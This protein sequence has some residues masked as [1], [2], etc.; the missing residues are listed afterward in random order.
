[1]PEFLKLLPAD[2]ARRILTDTRPVGTERVPLPSAAG[3]VLAEALA[4]PEDLPAWPRATMD[5][6]AVRAR[7]IG[8]ASDGTP[9]Y[10]SVVGTVP[11][12]GALAGR[13]GAAQAA[14]IS[15]GGM[16]PEGADAVVMIEYATAVRQGEIEV[17]KG[18]AAGDNVIRPGDDFR[19]GETVLPAGRRLRPQDLGGLAAFG[20]AEVAVHRRPRVAILSTGNEICEPTATPAPGQVRDINQYVLGAM[21]AA[22]GC[23][24]TYGGIVKDDAAALRE[25]IGRL[26][27]DHDGLVLSG[28]SSVGVRDVSAEVLSSIGSPGVIFHGISVR[29]GKPTLFARAGVKPVVGM[30]GYP[31]SSMIIFDG[32]VGPM[33]WR[34]GGEIGRPLWPARRRATLVRRC[35]SQAGRED[36]VRVRLVER[37]ARTFAEPLLGGS[38]AIANVVRADG[39]VIIPD[40][41][42]GI[43]EGDEVDVCLYV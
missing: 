12:G 7:D 33:L 36:Y 1:M 11:M 30:P 10:L 28:G 27:P 15:T 16:V 18:L 8:G 40:G 17:V 29:P 2:E 20:V 14:G 38:A 26:L 35:P 23:E 24:V 9:S 22:A 41:V 19:R 42:E 6:Y 5:G 25:A 4:A 37:D 43:A 21:I 31:T 34:L 32:F 39:L 13:I 3:R